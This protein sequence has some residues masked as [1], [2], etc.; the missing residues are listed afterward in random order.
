MNPALS[1]EEHILAPLGL[2]PG[3]NDTDTFMIASSDCNCFN[4]GRCVADWRLVLV[5]G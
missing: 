2:L 1:I 3:S 5:Q 4:A